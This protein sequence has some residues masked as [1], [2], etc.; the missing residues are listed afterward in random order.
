M[1]LQTAVAAAAVI[2]FRA[3]LE[4]EIKFCMKMVQYTKK[5]A[6]QR[7]SG[8]AGRLVSGAAPAAAATYRGRVCNLFLII[9]HFC[10]RVRVFVSR[11]RFNFN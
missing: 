1:K 6:G 7:Q 3:S 2:S 9:L 5:V 10:S 11:V 4:N 8:R